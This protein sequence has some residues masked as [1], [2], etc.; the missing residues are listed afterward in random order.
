MRYD[1]LIYDSDNILDAAD[2]SGNMIRINGLSQSESD[3]LC[4]IM[5]QHG[6]SIC[7]LPYKE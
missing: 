4:D 5:T 6:V 2:P 1:V 3:D 7:L